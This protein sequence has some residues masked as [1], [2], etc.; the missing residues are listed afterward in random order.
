[1]GGNANHDISLK[2][3]ANGS[4]GT[5][6]S[7]SYEYIKQKYLL[8]AMML[9]ILTYFDGSDISHEIFKVDSEQTLVTWRQPPPDLV[10]ELYDLELFKQLMTVLV[11]FAFLQRSPG[12]E[13]YEMHPVVQDWCLFSSSRD[14]QDELSVLALCILGASIGRANDIDFMKAES[15]RKRLKIHSARCLSLLDPQIEDRHCS[16]K[17]VICHALGLFGQLDCYLGD[18]D[19]AVVLHRRSYRGFMDILGLDKIFCIRAGLKLASALA[20]AKRCADSENVLEAILEVLREKDCKEPFVRIITLVNLAKTCAKFGKF[21]KAERLYR[22]VL[23]FYSQNKPNDYNSINI[24]KVGLGSLLMEE[25]RVDEAAEVFAEALVTAKE[26]W[27]GF[28]KITHGDLVCTKLAAAY[29]KLGKFEEAKSVL[30]VALSWFEK[31]YGI[32]DDWVFTILRYLGGAYVDLGQ[33][34]DEI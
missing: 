7:V 15:I 23:A 33:F 21:E 22:Q 10:I 26:L 18:Y 17:D 27:L 30:L 25:K 11:D 32:E 19:R 4:V 34:R 6:W 29:K 1:M 3:Y 12:R 14:E 13:T 5:T 20:F 16:H 8:A 31:A 24:A 2:D 9:K 28:P